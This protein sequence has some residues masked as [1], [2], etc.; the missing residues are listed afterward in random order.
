[1]TTYATAAEELAA[2]E[3]ELAALRDG[4]EPSPPSVQGGGTQDDDDDIDAVVFTNEIGDRM[5]SAE[6]ITSYAPPEKELVVLTTDDIP[7]TDKHGIPLSQDDRWR[8]NVEC[9]RYSLMTDGLVT[10]SDASN[11]MVGFTVTDLGDGVGPGGEVGKCS[12]LRLH[13]LVFGAV[14]SCPPVAAE[15]GRRER[16]DGSASPDR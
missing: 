5:V 13:S 3:A 14:R 10:Q 6:D 8:E 12:Q 1:M 7:T 4:S 11:N 15:L 9:G 2:L 16:R